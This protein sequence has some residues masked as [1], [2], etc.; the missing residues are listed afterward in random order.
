V[1]STVIAAEAWEA[2]VLAKAVLLR[3]SERAF[4]L[5]VP[6]RHAALIVDRLGAIR[7]SEGFEHFVNQPLPNVV[8]IPTRSI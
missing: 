2:E 8:P 1:F 6:G 7:V 5:L 4:D 3:G